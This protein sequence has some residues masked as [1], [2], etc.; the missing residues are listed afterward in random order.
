MVGAST[1]RR[2]YRSEKIARDH[3]T[4]RLE[5]R[6][7]GA[8]ARM[9]HYRGR[10]SRWEWWARQSGGGIMRRRRQCFSCAGD[11]RPMDRW[12]GPSMTRW[13]RCQHEDPQCQIAL[14]VGSAFARALAASP[15]RCDAQPDRG[16]EEPLRS[17][18]AAQHAGGPAERHWPAGSLQVRLPDQGLFVSAGRSSS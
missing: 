12:S 18:P 1:D 6:V 5:R 16:A 15:L 14:P 8:P 11:E 10:D 4:D 3:A 7:L 13:A 9:G 2:P 17:V